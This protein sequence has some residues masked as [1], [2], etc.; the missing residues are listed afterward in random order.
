MPPLQLLYGTLG[1]VLL[2][3]TLHPSVRRAVAG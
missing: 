2:I 1:L 3:L